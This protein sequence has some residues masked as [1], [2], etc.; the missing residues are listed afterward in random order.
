VSHEES[1]GVTQTLPMSPPRIC[2]HR[3]MISD[4]EE[5]HIA[6]RCAVWN[7]RR[8]FPISSLNGTTT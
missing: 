2:T 7:V 4:R 6:A 5:E 3:R 1:G 8:S